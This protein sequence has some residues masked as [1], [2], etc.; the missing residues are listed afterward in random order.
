[1]SDLQAST[2]GLTIDHEKYGLQ[3]EGNQGSSSGNFFFFFFFSF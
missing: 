2:M 3:T 1:M